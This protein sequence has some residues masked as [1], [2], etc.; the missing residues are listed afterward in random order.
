MNTRYYLV[1][2]KKRVNDVT[3]EI[4]SFLATF[5]SLPFLSVAFS[6]VNFLQKKKLEREK[7][8][9]PP[10]N[11][12]IFHQAQASI[13]VIT[14][15]YNKILFRRCWYCWLQKNENENFPNVNLVLS[16]CQLIVYLTI[17]V[18]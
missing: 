7:H 13:L 11:N 14:R 2:K 15:E 1:L 10:F 5:I 4:R 16:I 6:N 3:N 8:L 12:T 9:N 17:P 18:K